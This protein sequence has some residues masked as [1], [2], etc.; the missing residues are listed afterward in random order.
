MSAE[1]ISA[2]CA[3]WVKSNQQFS[4]ARYRLAC[5]G[6]LLWRPLSA[7]DLIEFYQGASVAEG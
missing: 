1:E 5:R 6:A 4:P 3:C 7:I 2:E